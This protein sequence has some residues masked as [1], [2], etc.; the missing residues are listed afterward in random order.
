MPAPSGGRAEQPAPELAELGAASGEDAASTTDSD[1]AP[2]PRPLP[3]RLATAALCAACAARPTAAAPPPGRGPRRGQPRGAGRAGLH[4]RGRRE[5]HQRRRGR[6][7]RDGLAP[8]PDQRGREPAGHHRPRRRHGT[9]APR[10]RAPQR[11]LPRVAPERV[12]PR[13][14]QAA[15]EEAQQPARRQFL[16]GRRGS[17]GGRVVDKKCS[18]ITGG[19]YP[20]RGT[21]FSCC[22]ATPCTLLNSH[23]IMS[24]CG[25]YDIAGERANNACPHA[26]GACYADEEMRLN[27]CYKKCVLLTEGTHA[28]RTAAETCC[29]YESTMQCMTHPNSSVTSPL[30]AVGGGEFEKINR[31]NMTVNLPHTPVKVEAE[32][33]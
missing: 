28:F 17:G 5:P 22:K 3:G 15:A 16:R 9:R 30:Y 13:E 8:G 2:R 32:A 23:F 20:F 11:D 27:T 19:V 14:A 29:K 18:L 26:R 21:A 33:P 4:A 31:S 12:Q 7:R 10:R 6:E 24:M 1:A 25:G